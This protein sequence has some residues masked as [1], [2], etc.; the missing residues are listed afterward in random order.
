MDVP[1]CIF[2]QSPTQWNLQRRLILRWGGNC[3]KAL[4][5]LKFSL[6][7]VV[8]AF[9][10]CFKSSYRNHVTFCMLIDL[11]LFGEY[12]PLDLAYLMHWALYA[13]DDQSLLGLQ[14]S[15][16][17]VNQ[18]W[19]KKRQLHSVISGL[20]CLSFTL[21]YYYKDTFRRAKTKLSH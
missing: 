4:Q 20:W 10:R 14:A 15:G 5:S 18:V 1:K 19:G 17:A 12:C 6:S 9:I 8:G 3:A 16:S 21:L 2:H 7:S 11:E 13:H